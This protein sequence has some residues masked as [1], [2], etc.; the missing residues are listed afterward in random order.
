[1]CSVS[2]SDFATCSRLHIGGSKVNF[3]QPDLSL[4]KAGSGMMVVSGH[5][6][7]FCPEESLCFLIPSGNLFCFLSCAISLRLTG[8]DTGS[9]L[10]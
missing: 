5:Y 3:Y 6:S 7:L 2:L 8:R 10:G 9:L 4:L 1:M